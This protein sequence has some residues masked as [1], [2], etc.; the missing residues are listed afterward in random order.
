[1]TKN[2]G[3]IVFKKSKRNIYKRGLGISLFVL[4]SM[5]I[6]VTLSSLML[7]EE[8]S[9][10]INR[11]D[12]EL[13]AKTQ[14]KNIDTLLESTMP[15]IVAVLS[16]DG[17]ISNND[18][19]IGSGVIC[20]EKGYILTVNH[21]VYGSDKI[22]VK[23]NNGQ[24][25]DARF[26]GYD[27]YSDIAILKIKENGLKTAKFANNNS[28]KL[29]ENTLLISSDISEEN[30]GGISRGI[31]NSISM[32]SDYLDEEIEESFNNEIIFSD[33][34][35]RKGS[36]GGVLINYNG[37]VVG[38]NNFNLREKI[39]EN[40][41]SVAVSVDKIA[42]TIDQIMRYGF[43][44]RP[45]IGIYGGNVISTKGSESIG[46]YI[47]DIKKD[48]G[49]DYAGLRPTDVIMEVND[50]KVGSMEEL[51]DIISKCNIGESVICKIKRNNSIERVTVR[52][53]RRD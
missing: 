20:N 2:R 52:L 31:I 36:D 12:K 34:F 23:L 43:I 42:D 19:T 44:S 13:N 28:L 50:I 30:L 33:V 24:I 45:A 53:G 41:Y 15:S 17:E 6:G 35:S 29:G 47:H 21:I 22:Q 1:M 3:N 27:K 10:D 8:I 26:V 14:E 49:A 51:I 32:Q 18:V 48:S 40:K 25:Y 5:I 9:A 4:T 11:E 46:V 7:N 16:F 38:I 39:D 37:E